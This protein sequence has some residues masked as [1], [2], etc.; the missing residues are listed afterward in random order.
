MKEIIIET[1]YRII[2][3]P[4]QFLFKQT[5][6]WDI[7]MQDFLKLPQ[8]S[9]GFQYGCFLLKYNFNIQATLEEH[10]VFHVLTNTGISVKD[11]IDMQFILLGNGKRSPFVF[12]VIA[13]GILFYPFEYKNFYE[14]YKQGKKAHRFYD[15][16]FYKMLTIPLSTIQQT[17]N[18]NQNE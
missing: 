3:V 15:L 18:L 6:A 9:L 14:K 1:L 16:D 5:K 13:T 12:I 2:K 7:S 17:F 4:Y 8:E 11:E 10:D